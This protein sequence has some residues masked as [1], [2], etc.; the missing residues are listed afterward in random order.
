M[1]LEMQNA[2]ER[3]LKDAKTPT[4]PRARQRNPRGSVGAKPHH[5]CGFGRPGIIRG[6]RRDSG[7]VQSVSDERGDVAERSAW[8]FRRIGMARHADGP[9]MGTAG[10][11]Q[12]RHRTAGKRQVV[13]MD[14]EPQLSISDKGVFMDKRKRPH[15]GQSRIRQ[16]CGQY[17]RADIRR[18]QRASALPGGRR[19]QADT[20]FAA[21][22][23]G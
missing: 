4:D 21:S 14:M 13:Q 23:G 9:R 18:R 16:H 3:E 5:G 17:V 20:D 15:G 19:R 6:G 2:L 12:S 1:T 10:A 11:V 8:A 7:R 22:H